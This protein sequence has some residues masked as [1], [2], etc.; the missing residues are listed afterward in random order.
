LAKRLST[1]KKKEI[2]NLFINGKFSIDELSNKFECTNPTIIRNLKKE[3]GNEKYQE[4]IALGKTKK[5]LQPSNEDMKYEGNQ[6]H[7]LFLN[8]D[9]PESNFVEL[10]PLDYEIE[11]IPRKELSSVPIEKI[12]FPKIVYMIVS[13][14]IELE[15]KLLKDYP[16][17]E[18]LPKEDLK[19]KTIEIYFDLKTAKRDCSKERKVIKVPNTDVFRIASS[20]LLNKGISRI[21]SA[22]KL[23]SI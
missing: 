10:T 8:V 11:N 18:F 21:V 20:F 9:E 4:I 5:N 3:L 1:L 7:S 16:E 19:R 14:N 12:E 2:L 13:K 22:E 6:N 15:I 23:I 17:W